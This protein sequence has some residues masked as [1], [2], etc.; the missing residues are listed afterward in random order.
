MGLLDDHP[1]SAYQW[2]TPADYFAARAEALFTQAVSGCQWYLRAET[3]LKRLDAGFNWVDYLQKRGCRVDAWT[4]NPP[5]FS[6]AST[7]ARLGVNELTSNAPQALA[8]GIK[9]ACRY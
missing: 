4:I 1:L 7:I 9:V 3:I 8:E 6:F 2:G 5:A